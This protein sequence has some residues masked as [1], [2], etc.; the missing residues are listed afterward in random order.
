VMGETPRDFWVSGDSLHIL[1]T[2]KSK[3]R[4]RG[5]EVFVK[6]SEGDGLRKR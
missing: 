5:F 1:Q 2:F 6:E 3:D 4:F